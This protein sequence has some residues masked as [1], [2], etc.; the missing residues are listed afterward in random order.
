VF[1]GSRI[2]I[3]LRLMCNFT[4]TNNVQQQHHVVCQLLCL[5][6]KVALFSERFP[7]LRSSTCDDAR[8]HQF[9]LKFKRVFMPVFI[10]RVC[11]IAETGC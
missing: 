4:D 10:K 9:P 5:G 1:S 3:C 11:R 6:I 7:L 2:I 8:F